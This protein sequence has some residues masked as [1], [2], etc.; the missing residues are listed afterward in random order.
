M[1]LH[2]TTV[3]GNQLWLPVCDNCHEEGPP[4]S[5]YDEFHAWVGDPRPSLQDAS[6]LCEDCQ[7]A[8]RPSLDEILDYLQN[9]RGGT[10][11][12]DMRP[13][14]SIRAAVDTLALGLQTE[15]LYEHINAE[16]PGALS[17]LESCVDEN[18]VAF[19]L[20]QALMGHGPL[21]RHAKSNVTMS[22]KPA[23]PLPDWAVADAWAENRSTG[24]THRI[25]ATTPRSVLLI[26]DAGPWVWMRRS[27]DFGDVFAHVS[28]MSR[29]DRVSAADFFDQSLGVS[30]K[31]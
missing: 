2:P 21:S 6:I 25:L 1:P 11:Y 14:S 17:D 4:I 9:L 24:Q 27:V 20:I 12:I 7:H 29:V 10:D 8:S 5:G 18:P 15:A 16:F 26:G 19:A 13:G 3:N 23:L 28:S 31:E 22:K 30:Q